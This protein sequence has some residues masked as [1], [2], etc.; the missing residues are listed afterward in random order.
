MTDLPTLTEVIALLR[1]LDLSS[2]SGV[3]QSP[4]RY[5]H[6]AERILALF[7]D[8]AAR[9]SPRGFDLPEL[10]RDIYLLVARILTEN[11]HLESTTNDILALIRKRDDASGDAILALMRAGALA[12]A[13]LEAL[14][15]IERDGKSLSPAV[16]EAVLEAVVALRSALFHP[17]LIPFRGAP[18]ETT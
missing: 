12:A 10:Q 5:A 16:M 6:D 7:R 14:A 4:T 18:K 17:A 2:A 13:P 15:L 3:P 8:I 9:Q 1:T 11:R